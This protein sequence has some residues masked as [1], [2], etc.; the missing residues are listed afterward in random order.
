MLEDLVAQ[1]AL[2]S[3]R[4]ELERLSSRID[5]FDFE[6]ALDTLDSLTRAIGAPTRSMD[7]ETQTT[8]HTS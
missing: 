2:R 4:A 1:P 7:H 5:E 6:Q 3:H 8:R